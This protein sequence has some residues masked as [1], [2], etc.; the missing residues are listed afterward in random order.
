MTVLEPSWI[1][2]M[3]D[4]SDTFP[5]TVTETPASMCTATRRDRLIDVHAG[6]AIGGGGKQPVSIKVGLQASPKNAPA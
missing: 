4:S 2:G 6:H 1:S 5:D 3:I